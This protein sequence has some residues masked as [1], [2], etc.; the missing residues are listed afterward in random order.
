MTADFHI[1]ERCDGVLV[2]ITRSANYG[3]LI[4]AVLIGAFAAYIVPRTTTSRAVLVLNSV[5]LGFNLFKEAI[6]CLRGTKVQ[7]RWGTLI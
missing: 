3:R 6:S 5:L 4:L 2:E 7:L 1:E